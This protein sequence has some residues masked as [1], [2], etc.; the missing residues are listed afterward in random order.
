VTTEL[1]PTV[2]RDL[3]LLSVQAW[4]LGYGRY[5]FE[6]LG[7]R[8]DIVFHYDGEKVNFYHPKPEFAY[9]KDVVTKRMMSDDELFAACNQ[10]FQDRVRE[11]KTLMP[12]GEHPPLGHIRELVGQIMSFYIFVVSDAFVAARPEAWASRHASEGVLYELDAQLEELVGQALARAG[13]EPQLAHV[14]SWAEAELLWAGKFE[15]TD[16]LRARRNGYILHNEKL[17]PEKDFSVYCLAQGWQNPETGAVQA[18]AELRGQSAF[19]GL[20][21]GP[22]RLVKNRED[23]AKAQPGDILV[24]IMT[25]ANFLPALRQAAAFVTDEGGVTC[26]AAIVARE[27]EKPCVVGTKIATSVLKDGDMVEVDAEAGIVRKV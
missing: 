14:V 20:A 26:H 4:Q 2:K 6:A 15:M 21:R 12:L 3:S 1:K 27:L 9:F 25:N 13:Y 8:L 17:V 5:L 19:P 7:W 23:V 10:N 24:A 11:L 16:A 18:V 22:V